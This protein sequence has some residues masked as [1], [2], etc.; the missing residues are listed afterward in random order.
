[1]VPHEYPSYYIAQPNCRAERSTIT[2]DIGLENISSISWAQRHAITPSTWL[3]HLFVMTLS[4]MDWNWI[5][6]SSSRM[7]RCMI[8]HEFNL[9]GL[10][11]SPLKLIPLK[12]FIYPYMFSQI[13]ELL[14]QLIPTHLILTETRIGS[15]YLTGEMSSIPVITSSAHL[16]HLYSTVMSE[17]IATRVFA[18]LRNDA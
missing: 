3:W 10:I 2:Q 16:Y 8:T 6:Q 7:W 13:M 14:I 4:N 17:K 18:I 5:T 15:G 1:M 9:Y 11:W 12:V